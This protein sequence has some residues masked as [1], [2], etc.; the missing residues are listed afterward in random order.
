MQFEVEFRATDPQIQ[1][2]NET[3]PFKAH[4]FLI[5]IP[6]TPN[7]QPN[8]ARI[9]TEIGLLGYHFSLSHILRR[10]FMHIRK[11][12]ITI[13]KIGFEILTETKY[14]NIFRI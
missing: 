4:F 12:W 13:N 8:T 6:S 9:A 5:L 14:K 1:P 2:Y 10:K 3:L 7:S 11:E